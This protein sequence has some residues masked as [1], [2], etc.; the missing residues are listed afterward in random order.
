MKELNLK[1]FLSALRVLETIYLAVSLL[2]LFSRKIPHETFQTLLSNWIYTSY[3]IL[4]VLLFKNIL[5]AVLNNGLLTQN[6]KMWLIVRC[7]MYLLLSLFAYP[8]I[9]GL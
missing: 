3:L 1:R 9:L 2:I 8:L 5:V 6:Q 7:A 4:P